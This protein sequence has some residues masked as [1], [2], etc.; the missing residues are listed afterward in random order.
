MGEAAG[1][2]SWVAAVPLMA[3]GYHAEM[4]SRA[5]DLREHATIY[6]PQDR[7]FHALELTS[8]DAVKVVILG[9]DPYH[10]AGQA[11]GLAFSVPEGVTPPPSLRNI[12]KEV[13]QDV[14][15]GRLP[16]PATDLSRWARQGVLLL[17]AIL[18]V[19]AGKPGSHEALGWLALTDAIIAALSARQARL[20][21][22]LWGR[23]AQSKRDKIDDRRH[24]V[25]TAPHPS[26]LSAHRGFFGSGHFSGANAYLEAHGQTPI[27]W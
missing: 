20:V 8:F 24:L 7:I 18:T 26:P 12:L 5:R 27:R 21:F 23:F 22:M 9:Q 13:A 10:G 16:S 14:Y 11:H 25:L 3:Q 6:P 4:A 1:L 2:A 15:A 19:E 17:N